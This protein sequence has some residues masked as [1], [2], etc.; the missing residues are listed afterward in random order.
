MTGF[1]SIPKEMFQILLVPI[2]LKLW[3]RSG[4]WFTDRKNDFTR[5]VHRQKL[6]VWKIKSYRGMNDAYLIISIEDGKNK[7]PWTMEQ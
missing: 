4:I 5:P 6:E 2:I 7:E 1:I 3:I